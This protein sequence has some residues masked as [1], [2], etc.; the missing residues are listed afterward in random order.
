M[1]ISGL[2]RTILP[3]KQSF[4]Q[5]DQGALLKVIQPENQRR[6]KL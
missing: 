3:S 1:R 5:H 2:K 6:L 4:A